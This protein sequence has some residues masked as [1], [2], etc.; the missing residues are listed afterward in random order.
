MKTILIVDDD[1]DVR[2][3]MRLVLHKNGFKVLEAENGSDALK[4]AVAKMPD[5]IISDVMMDNINGFM[6]RE[7]LQKD[8]TTA[9]IPMILITGAAQDA[10]AWESDKSVSYLRKPFGLDLLLSEVMK[11]I[12]PYRRRS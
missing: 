11:K 7:M 6:L 8:K 10:G 1:I 9:H 2:S 12:F 5:L 3:V 4:L